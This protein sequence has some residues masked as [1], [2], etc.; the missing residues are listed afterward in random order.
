MEFIVIF[1]LF[2]VH[3]LVLHGVKVLRAGL[4]PVELVALRAGVAVRLAR[5]ER[6]FVVGRGLTS[7]VVVRREGGVS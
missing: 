4:R 3:L 5:R 1:S 2:F 7:A 6:G